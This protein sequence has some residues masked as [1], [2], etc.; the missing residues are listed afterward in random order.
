MKTTLRYVLLGVVLYALF[1]LM[2]VPAAWLYGHGLRSRLGGMTMYGVQGTLWSGQAAALRSGAV[3]LEDV[4]WAL[5]PWALLW[6][7]GEAALD[8]HYQDAPGKM[9]A[10]RS[11]SGDWYMHDV[12]LELP[13]AQ[14][15]PMLRMPGAELGG[16]LLLHLDFLTVKHGRVTAAEG[17]LNWEKA[18]LRRPVAVELGSF[19]VTLKT[20]ADGVNGVLIDHGGAVQA[21]GVFKLQPDG[22]YQ[23]TATFA[24]RNP[25]QSPVGQGLRLFGA[26]GP[27][28]RVRYSTAGRLPPL[29][30]G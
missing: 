30:P 16:R 27:D 5:H 18:S 23:L 13:A 28:G 2:T 24:A 15:M 12:D 3:Q 22:R 26:P 1:M 9:V 19:V 14:L 29:L 6:G 17:T 21:Q 20:T 11:L 7:R 4:R 10:A 8:F 25:Q